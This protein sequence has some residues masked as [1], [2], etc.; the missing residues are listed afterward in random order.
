MT[1]QPFIFTWPGQTVEPTLSQ[2]SSALGRVTV[3]NSDKPVEGW[4]NLGS[5]AYFTE[6][7]LT[8][9]KLFDGDIFFHVQADAT[10]QEWTP[11]IERARMLNER[12]GWDNFA[13]LVDYT[14]HTKT[15]CELEPN[16]YSVPVN[17]CTCWM[18]HARLIE[19]YLALDVDW[20]VNRFGWGHDLVMAALADNVIRD[21]T[22]TVHH[23]RHTGYPRKLATSQLNAMLALL[24]EDVRAKIRR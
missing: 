11:I 10:S 21:H 20:S 19:R 18:L 13:P 4:V 14:Y 16:V 12:Y 23:P 17:D 9:L 3:I 15:I 5:E 2:L 7:F 22:Y 24:P 1:I 6:Q 8:A